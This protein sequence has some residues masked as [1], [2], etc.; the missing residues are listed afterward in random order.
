MSSVYLPLVLGQ[1]H[2][3]WA[4]H[5][6]RQPAEADVHGSWLLACDPSSWQS[7]NLRSWVTAT[8]GSEPWLTAAV[9]A[10]CLLYCVCHSYTP[11]LLGHGYLSRSW[12]MATLPTWSQVTAP[13]PLVLSHAWLPIF[14]PD[15]QYHCGNYTVG[16]A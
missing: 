16:S 12:V 3:V 6:P 2:S 4:G 5:L 13:P 7:T 14:G 8:P 9:L 11:L 10:R 15:F 1:G